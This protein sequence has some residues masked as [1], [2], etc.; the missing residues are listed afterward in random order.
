M[1]HPGSPTFTSLQGLQSGAALDATS[2]ALIDQTNALAAAVPAHELTPARRRALMHEAGQLL[3]PA[4][5]KSSVRHQDIQIPLAGRHLLARLYEPEALSSDVLLVFFHGGGWVLGDLETHHPSMQFLAQH[6]GM[7]LLSVQYRKAP[8]H[9]FPAAC[10]D[11]QQ[12]LVWAH[13]QLAS[14]DCKRI[15]VSGD[16]AGGHLAAVAMHSQQDVPVAGAFLFYPVTDMQFANRSYTERGAGPGLTRDGMRWF[17]QQFLAPHQTIDELQ[18]KRD[19]RAVP[20]QQTWA[21]TPPPTVILAAW[22][23]PLYD[24]A[25]SYA[26]LLAKA[27]AAVVLQSAPDLAHGFLRHAA[28]VDSAR[29]HVLAAIHAFRGLIRA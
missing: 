8:E 3:L 14:W 23:D 12:S 27:G 24:E 17:W 20:M 25:V 29:S 6:V 9:V 1:E 11:A 22:H 4:D 21:L 10:D 19:A 13:E 28:L 16:S 18:P 7:K 26:N 5:L 2:R 15:A